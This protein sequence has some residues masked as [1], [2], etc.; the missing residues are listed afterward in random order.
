MTGRLDDLLDRIRPTGS[1]GAAG[2]GSRQRTLD[3]REH[4]IA[5]VVALLT[6]FEAAAD[7]IVD[8]ARRQSQQITSN[9]HEQCRRIE[10]EVPDRVATAT[11]AS[12]RQNE[13]DTEASRHEIIDRAASEVTRIN[14]VAEA[15]IAALVD[16]ATALVW[17]GV[18]PADGNGPEP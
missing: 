5:T 17:A 2:D 15:K 16:A 1:P 7:A 14:E 18:S 4:E 9:A 3:D 10:S 8:E 11:T 13:R 12:A 6:E